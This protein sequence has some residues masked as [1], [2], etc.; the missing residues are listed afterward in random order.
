MGSEMCIRD[1]TYSTYAVDF[2]T[3]LSHVLNPD[4]IPGVLCMSLALWSIIGY[5]CVRKISS[6]RSLNGDSE[7][8]RA[9]DQKLMYKTL[10]LSNVAVLYIFLHYLLFPLMRTRFFYSYYLIVF[11][12]F[13]CACTMVW[14]SRK[15]SEMSQQ[16]LSAD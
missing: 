16:T 1:R 8:M 5:L 11:V 9:D 10:V 4:W 14:R 12:C 7:Y 2:K 3:Y 15:S 13:G 6:D